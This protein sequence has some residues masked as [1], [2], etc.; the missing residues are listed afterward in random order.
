M[1]LLRGKTSESYSGLFELL[2]MVKGVPT[3]YY[4]DLQETKLTLWRLMDNTLTC[5]EEMNGMMATLKV[6][7]EKMWRQVDGS[8][9]LATELAETLVTDAKLSFRESYKV[10]A[11]LVN[12]TISRGATLNTLATSDVESSIEK[13]YGKKIKIPQSLVDK[14]TDPKLSLLRRKSLG[15]PHPDEVRRMVKE[16]GITAIQNRNELE[17]KKAVVAKAL[18]KLTTLAEHY[19]A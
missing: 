2:T 18:E 1:E 7:P 8:F 10:A 15:S 6:K 3:G 4:Q 12:L 16:H 9:V 17:T 13:L 19:S 11:D 14:S 5:T